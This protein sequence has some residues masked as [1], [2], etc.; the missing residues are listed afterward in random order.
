M[1]EARHQP[2]TIGVRLYRHVLDPAI[3]VAEYL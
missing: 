1:M 2:P 3:A